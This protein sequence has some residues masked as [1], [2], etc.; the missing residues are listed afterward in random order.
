MRFERLPRLAVGAVVVAGSLAVAW[1]I[2]V[3]VNVDHTPRSSVASP[4]TT[5]S[6]G[7]GLMPRHPLPES[8]D[9]GEMLPGP[10]EADRWW[11]QRLTW[12]WP[13]NAVPSSLITEF[14]TRRIVATVDALTTDALPPEIRMIRAVP[15][16]FR[17]RAGEADG[18][19]SPRNAERYEFLVRRL[20]STNLEAAIRLYRRAYPMLQ[21][22]Y[23]ALG[24]PD[25]YFNDRLI[26]VLDHLLAAPDVPADA[27]LVA[28]QNGLWA[29]A[30]PEFERMSAGHKLMWRLG[31]SN[32]A[33]VKIVLRGAR[34]RLVER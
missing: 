1:A 13:D 31:P 21:T 12:L 25:G 11:R 32:A 22:A 26:E 3:F 7:A 14:F 34:E 2:F 8:T 5:P 27:R 20:E 29:F 6:A 24:H 19:Y 33:R 15:G 9:G 28:R 18:E 16:T 30:D 10:E 23:G 17:V 4:A